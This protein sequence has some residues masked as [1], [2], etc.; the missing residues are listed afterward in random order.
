MT[1]L[2]DEQV[3]RLN[4]RSVDFHGRRITNATDAKAPQDY[5]TLSQMEEAVKA[6]AG[7]YTLTVEGTLAIGSDLADNLLI[8][9][10][11]KVSTVRAQ[12]KTAPLGDNLEI[13]IFQNGTLWATITIPD[14]SAIKTMTP[15]ELS[16]L[17]VLTANNFFRI[18]IITVGASS[19][20]TD[21]TLTVVK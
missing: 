15:L 19:P 10:S 4:A 18:D 3:D 16:A 21:L 17:G 1:K 2:R 7:V 8:T 13:Q 11:G 9:G 6:N 12:V 5:V 14:G 20:G